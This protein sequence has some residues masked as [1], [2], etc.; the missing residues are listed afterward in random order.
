LLSGSPSSSVAALTRISPSSR[1]TTY[2]YA[3]RGWIGCSSLASGA[4]LPSLSFKGSRC[5]ASHK[6]F[7]SAGETERPSA[8]SRQRAGSTPRVVGEATAVAYFVSTQNF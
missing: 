5:Q 3:Y 4:G 1:S 2:R 7:A 8:V 6:P